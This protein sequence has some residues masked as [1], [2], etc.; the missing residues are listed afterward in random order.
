MK[1]ARR[2]TVTGKPSLRTEQPETNLKENKQQTV[3]Q[4]EKNKESTV[5][6][7]KGKNTEE[8]RRAAGADSRE[9]NTLQ[10]DRYVALVEKDKL[11]RM[12]AA[13]NSRS[14]GG[15]DLSGLGRNRL[16]HR[17][18]PLFFPLERTHV[19]KERWFVYLSLLE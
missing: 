2:S 9:G 7:G 1:E 18:F 19:K 13:V 10:G 3:E 12:S 5:E 16:R 6:K 8:N 15:F 17:V 4:E 11:T 14:N